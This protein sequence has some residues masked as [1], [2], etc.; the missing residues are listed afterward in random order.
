ML[1]GIC[2]I[3]R[4][5]RCTLESSA[6]VALYNVSIGVWT[7]NIALVPSIISVLDE[8]SVQCSNQIKLIVE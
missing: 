2:F 7:M 8:Q 6:P 3:C 5:V 4:L 1:N